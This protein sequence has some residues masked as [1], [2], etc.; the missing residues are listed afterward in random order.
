MG[1]HSRLVCLPPLRGLSPVG[2]KCLSEEVILLLYSFNFGSP[3]K[4]E[5]S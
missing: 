2:S 5:N 4:I 3:V 1:D